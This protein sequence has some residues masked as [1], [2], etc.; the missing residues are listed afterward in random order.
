MVPIYT[1]AAVQSNVRP[2]F[3]DRSGEPVIENMTQNLDRAIALIERLA[4]WNPSKI[5]LLPE[6]FMTGAGGVG[7]SA[8]DRGLLCVRIPGPEIERL[9]DLAKTV[10][11]YIAGMVWEIMDDWPDRYWNTAFICSPEGEVVLKYHNTM[12][13][14]V[15]R[16]L[17]TYWR[18]MSIAMVRMRC[19]RSLTRRLGVWDA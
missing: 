7:K 12:T 5:Y 1:A 2:V 17:V 11:G 3:P 14:S 16:N 18:N 13:L 8:K 15:R 10:D 4:E 19:S 6:F 9:C